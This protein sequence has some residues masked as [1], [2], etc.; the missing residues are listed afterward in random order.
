MTLKSLLDTSKV[1]FPYLGNGT[2]K[3]FVRQGLTVL[4]VPDAG[5]CHLSL[6]VIT[7]I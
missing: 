7:Q 2:E 5:S 6:K 1:R 3:G 4:G